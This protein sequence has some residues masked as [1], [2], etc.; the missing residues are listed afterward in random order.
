MS[1]LLLRSS[2]TQTKTEGGRGQTGSVVQK[3]FEIVK[4][5]D[6]AAVFSSVHELDRYLDAMQR[7]VVRGE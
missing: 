7:K 4:A 6:L 3:V 5:A 1:S 2:L